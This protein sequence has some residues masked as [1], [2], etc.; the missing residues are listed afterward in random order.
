ML[1]AASRWGHVEKSS[2]RSDILTDIIKGIAVRII[3][4]FGSPSVKWNFLFQFLRRTDYNAFS[5]S[6]LFEEFHFTDTLHVMR[7]EDCVCYL[8]RGHVAT[9]VWEVHLYN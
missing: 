2:C 1:M 3:V 4:L 8:L 5:R 9:F 7:Q 6:V